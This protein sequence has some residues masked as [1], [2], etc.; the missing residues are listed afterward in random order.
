MP[1]NTNNTNLL[2]GVNQLIKSMNEL[3]TATGNQSLNPVVNVSAPTVNIDAPL[4]PPAPD[5][6]VNF[7][8]AAIVAEL[9]SIKDNVQNIAT[10][11]DGLGNLLQIAGNS[12]HWTHLQQIPNLVSGQNTSNTHFA[13]I[14]DRL[15]PDGES[16]Q[17]TLELLINALEASLSSVGEIIIDEFPTTDITYSVSNSVKCLASKRAVGFPV[18][19]IYYVK[20]YWA[21]AKIAAISEIALMALLTAGAPFALTAGASAIAFQSI[22]D[23]IF[24]WTQFDIDDFYSEFMAIA[25]DLVCAIYSAPTAST[26]IDD[27]QTVIDGQTWSK[28]DSADVAKLFTPVT[29]INKVFTSPELLEPE[30]NYR[31]EMSDWTGFDCSSCVALTDCPGMINEIKTGTGTLFSAGQPILNQQIRINAA[32]YGAEPNKRITITFENPV[33]LRVVAHTDGAVLDYAW[34]DCAEYEC[35]AYTELT[36]GNL[37]LAHDCYRLE[38][39]RSVPSLS[40]FYID[41]I[42]STASGPVDCV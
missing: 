15:A 28:L 42:L 40:D 33:N 36:N 3:V 11:T 21:Y 22:V 6:T 12:D 23:K 41:V 8:T 13:N 39:I 14:A 38:V 5:V 29:H 32:V 9:S 17:P 24:T 19:A 30:Y 4:T 25:E 26:A 31:T 37:P 18:K 16:I 27:Y 7:D 20:R 10:D 2:D 35:A 34:Q 1:G